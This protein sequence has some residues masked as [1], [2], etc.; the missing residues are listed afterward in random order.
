MERHF[1]R[2]FQRLLCCTVGSFSTSTTPGGI[3]V[4]LGCTVS[5]CL[6]VW[7]PMFSLT[8]G[9]ALGKLADV[10]FIVELRRFTCHTCIYFFV[11]QR[12]RSIPITT[13]L[14]LLNC[15]LS[16]PPL[17]FILASM[18]AR[19]L[20]SRAFGRCGHADISCLPLSPLCSKRGDF[21]KVRGAMF[22]RQQSRT[23]RVK[24]KT[25][26]REVLN[27]SKIRKP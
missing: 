22:W 11:S 4:G 25:H 10:Y 13:L 2:G 14:C 20:L 17:V 16:Q 8:H 6:A 9:A 7:C 5:I 23:V 26:T 12:F 27:A 24:L 21:H 1:G 19:E 15:H 18:P 3:C